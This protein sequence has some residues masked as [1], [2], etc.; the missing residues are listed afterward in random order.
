M[1]NRIK[2]KSNIK[3]CN[4]IAK[5]YHCMEYYSAMA[6][7]QKNISKMEKEKRKF[8]TS[9]N[10][11]V[12]NWIKK[13]K[14][15]R[16]Q[17]SKGM[18]NRLR[19]IY[20]SNQHSVFHN[21]EFTKNTNLLYVV[22]SIPILMTAYRKI[23]GNKGAT[24]KGSPL[25]TQKYKKLNPSQRDFYNKTLPT[26][27]GMNNTIFSITSKLLRQGKYPWG[28]SKRVYVDK[29]GKPEV[30][31][32]I[33][34][35][36]F[37]D[38]VVQ[39]A[40]SQILQAIYEPVFEKQNCSFG[41][42]PHKGVHDAIYTLTHRGAQGLNYAIEGDIKAAYDKV[43][44]KKLISILEKRIKDRKF[45]KLIS[46]RL[47]YEYWDPLEKS[48]IQTDTGIPQGGID[49][50]YLWNIYMLEFD[51]YVNTYTQDLF[52]KKNKKVRKSYPPTRMIVNPTVKAIKREQN[53][54]KYIIRHLNAHT[55]HLTLDKLLKSNANSELK[56]LKK[57][58]IETGWPEVLRYKTSLT[59]YKYKII[60]KCRL[61]THKSRKMH[62]SDV[63]R[64]NLR[65]I[66][67]RY[68][69][70]FIILTNA[71]PDIMT[72]LRTQFSLYLKEEL[73]AELA[74]EKTLITDMKKEPAK[75][76]GFEIH[77]YSHSKIG[78]YTQTVTK[79]GKKT[80]IQVTAKVAGKQV[81]AFPDR[82]RLISRLH[83][84]GYCDNTGFP[85]GIPWISCL[86]A[87]VIIERFN[88]VIRGLCNYYA[89][90]IR[91][92]STHL[93]RWV[94][95]LRYSCIKTL[96]QKYK[97]SIRKL[98]TK[99]P[100]PRSYHTKSKTISI[101]IS[102]NYGDFNFK[103]TWTLLTLD[104]ALREAMAIKRYSTVENTYWT[105]KNNIPVKYT[106]KNGQFPPITGEK[107]L[108][109]LQW[110]NLR[111]S[112]SFDSPC[113]ICGSTLQVEMHHIKH[114]RKREYKLIPNTEFWTKVMSLRNRNQIPVCKECH[115]LIHA[116]KYGGTK[117]KAFKPEIMYDNRLITLESTIHKGIDKDYY[118]TLEEKGWQKRP[119]V[120]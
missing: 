44:R 54:L 8:A 24:T 111:T 9:R 108:E 93:S 80:Q 97:T 37:M 78:T 13:Y 119:R 57:L 70:D 96:A 11:H 16:L 84:K 28:T 22:S 105:L 45:L 99:F 62:S 114:I 19:N 90:F 46:D 21:K 69:D 15:E 68:A 59:E 49:S 75:F 17:K 3:Y 92:P 85:I 61:L 107:Y 100:G 58:I 79:K 101:S 88:A 116:G 18:L 32:P 20:L 6:Y 74:L 110:V 91:S 64:L 40:I 30:K 39:S 83:M 86:E 35:P 42:R 1:K 95:I 51:Q 52:D 43:N 26:P 89:E 106:A 82:Q 55:D 76:L 60:N 7:Q 5:R 27:D 33:T 112:A 41:F 50:P 73:H 103:K 38:R 12:S 115:I 77:T 98:L 65:F 102:Q 48:H 56:A 87:F 36:P 120:I 109:R 113:C 14:N 71:T 104:A 117:I 67:C 31:R 81:F 118:R 2:L 66:Y 25:S 72:L 63:K 34:I 4:S 23:R 53:S 47:N 10:K 29:P 94:Y